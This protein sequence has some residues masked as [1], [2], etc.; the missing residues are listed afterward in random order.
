MWTGFLDFI[1]DRIQEQ[2]LATPRPWPPGNYLREPP[3]ET[4]KIIYMNSRPNHLHELK[5]R[6]KLQKRPVH[7]NV[8]HNITSWINIPVGGDWPGEGFPSH[9]HPQVVL[10]TTVPRLNM[11]LWPWTDMFQHPTSSRLDNIGSVVQLLDPR[12]G[13]FK[14]FIYVY[15]FFSPWEQPSAKMICLKNNIL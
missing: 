10:G 1:E 2:T 15:V 6:A 13:T 14:Y 7:V 8:F 9:P 12:P 5:T 3:S 11:Y 4:P